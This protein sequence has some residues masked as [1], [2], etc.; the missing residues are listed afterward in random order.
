MNNTELAILCVIGINV[1][2]Y[3]LARF[4]LAIHHAKD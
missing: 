1:G 2:L 3:I 4:I